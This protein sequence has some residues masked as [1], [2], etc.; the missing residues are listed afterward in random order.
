MSK[1][2]LKKKVP[3][4]TRYKKYRRARY[5]RFEQREDVGEYSDILSIFPTWVV[6]GWLYRSKAVEATPADAAAVEALAAYIAELDAATKQVMKVPRLR[7]GM[8]IFVK[9]LTGKTITLEVEPSDS[10]ENVKAKIHDKEGTPLGQQRLIFGGKQLEDGR[11]LSDYNIQKEC[12]LHLVLR[13]YGGSGHASSFL[14]L[15]KRLADQGGLSYNEGQ[16]NLF[17][18][19]V[20]QLE[21]EQ[22]RVDDEFGEH[23]LIQVLRQ[24]N[25]L[26]CGAGSDQDLS[27]ANCCYAHI[28]RSN[29]P[30]QWKRKCDKLDDELRLR[31]QDAP[32]AG[33]SCAD[34]LHAIKADGLQSEPTDEWKSAFQWLEEALPFVYETLHSSSEQALAE[35]VRHQDLIQDV[36]KAARAFTK[37]SAEK[38]LNLWPTQLAGILLFVHEAE[39][40]PLTGTK[41]AI[42]MKT[43]EGKTFVCAISAAIMAKRSNGLALIL[44]A[45]QDRAADDLKSTTNFLVRYLGKDKKPKLIEGFDINAN[46]GSGVAYG[47]VT[48][49]QRIAVD[50]LRDGQQMQLAEWLR[51]CSVFVDEM[52]HVLIEQAESLLY[53]ASPCS[54][55]H[56]LSEIFFLILVTLD[57][58]ADYSAKTSSVATTIEHKAKSLTE[59]ILQA[60][61]DDEQKSGKNL[62]PRIIDRDV[63]VANLAA[64]SLSARLKRKCKEFVLEL[65]TKDDAGAIANVQKITIMDEAVGTEADGTR[66]TSMAAF[67]EGLLGLPVGGSDPLAFFNAL[68]FTLKKVRW[69]GGIT[70]T[71]GSNDCLDFFAKTYNIRA[72]FRVPRYVASTTYHLPMVVSGNEKGWL[73]NIA[74]SVDK[75]LCGKHGLKASGPILIVTKSIREASLI[76]KR[77]TCQNQGGKHAITTVSSKGEWEVEGAAGHEAAHV[78]PYYRRNHNLPERLPKAAVVIASNKGGRGVDLKVDGKCCAGCTMSHPAHREDTDMGDGLFVILTDVLPDRQDLQAQGRQGRGGKS[79]FVQYQMLEKSSDDVAT[80]TPEALYLRRKLCKNGNEKADLAAKI[81]RIC[82]NRLEGYVLDHFCHWSTGPYGYIAEWMKKLFVLMQTELDST[83][84]AIQAPFEAWLRAYITE[85]W[86]IWQGYGGNRRK[87]G[88]LLAHFKQRMGLRPVVDL[89]KTDDG[90]NTAGLPSFAKRFWRFQLYLRIGPEALYKLAK[91]LLIA[92][93]SPEVRG[94]CIDILDIASAPA[95]DSKVKFLFMVPNDPWRPEFTGNAALL[96][97]ALSPK[98]EYLDRAIEMIEAMIYNWKRVIKNPALQGK[99]FPDFVCDKDGEKTRGSKTY[100]LVQVAE[101][102]RQLEFRATS[103]RTARQELEQ[104][105]SNPVRVTHL[106][107]GRDSPETKRH[108][109]GLGWLWSETIF[110]LYVGP[111]PFGAQTEKWAEW[112]EY[113]RAEEDQIAEASG[114]SHE[115][116]T[117]AANSGGSA[118]GHGSAQVKSEA[119]QGQFSNDGAALTAALSDVNNDDAT[120]VS[121]AAVTGQDVGATAG[122]WEPTGPSA[123][124]ASAY[125]QGVGEVVKGWFLLMYDWALC[126]F[127]GPAKQYKGIKS[128]CATGNNAE[129]SATDEAG[130]QSN[131]YLEAAHRKID[132]QLQNERKQNQTNSADG[133][134]ELYLSE[135]ANKIIEITASLAPNETT[136]LFQDDADISTDGTANNDADFS[137]AKAEAQKEAEAPVHLYDEHLTKEDKYLLT[138]TLEALKKLAEDGKLDGFDTTLMALVRAIAAYNNYATSGNP[139]D[140]AVVKAMNTAMKQLWQTTLQ[141]ALD[142]GGK[143]S[144]LSTALGHYKALKEQQEY[145][146]KF[147][148]VTTKVK[149]TVSKVVQ[150]TKDVVSWVSGWVS[151]LWGKVK[152][153]VTK[154]VDVIKQIPIVRD[155]VNFVKV[156]VI[157]PVFAAAKNFFNKVSSVM[158]EMWTSLSEAVV[159]A[160]KTGWNKIAGFVSSAVTFLQRYARKVWNKVTGFFLYVAKSKFGKAGLKWGKLVMNLSTMATKSVGKWLAT[161]T[162]NV[163]AW[164]TT[165]STTLARFATTVWDATG[166]VMERS[167]SLLT[168]LLQYVTHTRLGQAVIAWCQSV[169]AWAS[170]SAHRL[171]S[172]FIQGI[173][174]RNSLVSSVMDSCSPLAFLKRH[175]MYLFQGRGDITAD[176]VWG[177]LDF[178]IVDLERHPDG[179][180]SQRIEQRRALQQVWASSWLQWH[181]NPSIRLGLDQDPRA[182]VHHA[183]QQAHHDYSRR[184]NADSQDTV[185]QFAR[186]GF[187]LTICIFVGTLLTGGLLLSPAIGMNSAGLTVYLQQ[188]SIDIENDP[189]LTQEE[190]EG[191]QTLISLAQNVLMGASLAAGSFVSG[192][193]GGDAEVATGSIMRALGIFFTKFSKTMQQ[194][195]E[196]TRV[197]QRARALAQQIDRTLRALGLG[198]AEVVQLGLTGSLVKL[199]DVTLGMVN[200]V[201]GFRQMLSKKVGVQGQDQ[202]QDQDQGQDQDQDQGGGE[203]QDDSS[204]QG[205][206]TVYQDTTSDML[207]N[208]DGSSLT[209]TD[210]QVAIDAGTPSG[211]PLLSVNGTYSSFT[212]RP[213]GDAPPP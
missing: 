123:E 93:S 100:Y 88:D 79:G 42:Q 175:I 186:V 85:Q 173:K 61:R 156:T 137:S 10:I 141:L 54:S 189:N 163:R 73:N 150:A 83:M 97:A 171:W 148:R 29:D 91:A 153:V 71:L 34:V 134:A 120:A 31:I 177:N 139:V 58:H 197:S 52:D 170:S 3:V 81:R 119:E 178:D 47:Q 92:K 62:H 68:P 72:A 127:Y 133:L 16:G 103:I 96:L 21:K 1:R 147:E 110:E 45:S 176:H 132:A 129:A 130:K 196:T 192:A 158:T 69:F 99:P 25:A 35:S 4:A 57:H 51:T 155:V 65:T 166:G 169:S 152:Q 17:N 135:N 84:S 188:L 80:E 40:G 66:W 131:P 76:R 140:P 164:L 198:G 75:W 126:A 14:C 212:Y 44:T 39:T 207:V 195:T 183:Q 22:L 157:N 146:D 184:M 70:G 172:N 208:S 193:G 201:I 59:K 89:R 128:G 185:M 111:E 182:H 165:A 60:L 8:Q 37:S 191:I 18:D 151:W 104:A 142:H 204:D 180:S 48:D 200:D 13:L 106:S 24:P 167:L 49:I 77:L 27:G 114:L 112:M 86:A 107:R 138:K 206:A 55:Y 202:D 5:N 116:G 118:G 108:A 102:L 136:E 19:V 23:V 82:Q 26:Y 124:D 7:G 174:W 101:I 53:I 63:L 205:G 161:A 56:A 30:S 179:I 74:E 121:E 145:T 209:K 211:G 144:G 36:I 38:K 11:T 95:A 15:S 105:P 117:G 90:D 115:H 41:S 87:P 213:A 159:D 122:E 160:V 6:I 9:T 20:E 50:A 33:R 28:V 2:G 143:I 210:T 194:V 78:F 190:K 181:L 98:P 43:G 67:V 109:Y 46:S 149:E 12:T 187:A 203:Q 162:K 94:F 168:G 125:K 32:G 64:G 113:L 199:L 154:V